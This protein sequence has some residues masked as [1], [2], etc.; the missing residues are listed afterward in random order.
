MLTGCPNSL[1]GMPSL[2]GRATFQFMMSKWGLR[3]DPA[4]PLELPFSGPTPPPLSQAHI[5]V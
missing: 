1:P 2:P 3:E 4:S 5:G